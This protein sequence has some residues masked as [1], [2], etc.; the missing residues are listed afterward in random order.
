MVST[1]RANSNTLPDPFDPN[2]HCSACGSITVGSL[3]VYRS[4]YRFIHRMVLVSH[5]VVNPNATIELSS[6]N[7]YCAQCEHQYQSRV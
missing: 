7:R 1:R 5:K 6:P 2:F 3:R 4:H